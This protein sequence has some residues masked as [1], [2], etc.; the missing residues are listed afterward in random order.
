MILPEHVEL[1]RSG[2][3]AVQTEPDLYNYFSSTSIQRCLFSVSISYI[4]TLLKLLS[5]SSEEPCIIY[6]N[7][8][9]ITQSIAKISPIQWVTILAHMQII[10]MWTLCRVGTM[11]KFFTYYAGIMCNVFLYLLCS[12]LC[13]HNWPRPTQEMMS[14]MS[15]FFTKYN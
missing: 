13:Q 5:L 7:R 4:R 15:L 1:V 12:N 9:K 11:H 10:N 14:V 6:I 2:H 8:W 3:M